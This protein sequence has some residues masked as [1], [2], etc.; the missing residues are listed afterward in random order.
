MK[1][2]SGR[3]KNKDL[4]RLRDCRP[5]V[6]ELTGVKRSEEAIYYW[7]VKGLINRHGTKVFLRTTRRIKVI[8]TTKQWLDDFLR[9]I[10]GV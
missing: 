7:A 9:S 4:L 1:V 3:P 8:Y 6:E 5:I 10:E 2:P